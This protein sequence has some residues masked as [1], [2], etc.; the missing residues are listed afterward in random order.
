MNDRIV[1]GIDLGTQGL[2][3][4]AARA[5]DAAVLGEASA[6][7]QNLAPAPGWMEQ[8]PA[9]WWQSLCRLTRQLLHEMYFA[10]ERVAGIGLSGHMH[11]IAPLRADGSL[12]HN[13]IVWADTRTQAQAQFLAETMQA[14]LWNPAIAPYS[15][16][17]ILWL[18]ERRPAVYDETATVLFSKD[19]LRWRL[20]GELATDYSDASGSLMWDFQ[21]RTWDEALLADLDIPLSLLPQARDS[22]AQAGALTSEAASD[23]GLLPGT[24][25]AH[26]GGDAACAVVGAG[27]AGTDTLL[28]NAGTAV[29]VIELV[30]APTPF[31]PQH[32]VR[33]LFE[34]GVDGRR[35]VIGALNSAGHS[36]DWWRRTL[37]PA[38]SHADME[39]LAA[40]ETGGADGAIF[41]PWLQGTGTPY[42]LD[43]AHGVFAQLSATADQASLTRAVMDGVAMGMRLC[44]ESMLGADGLAGTRI[45]FTGGVPKGALMRRILAGVF[46]GEIRCRAFSDMSA[47][48][49]AAHGAVACGLADDAGAWLADFDYGEVAQTADESLVAEYDRMYARYKEWAGR[50]GAS[51]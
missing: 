38:R 1:L 37:D 28:I 34:L 33:Y 42:L 19:W 7:V 41:L 35:F 27:I 4:I 50:I 46:G 11:S 36:L 16:A 48:G 9:A 25:V 24:I 32:A 18:R 43:G 14:R 31:H 29:Q 44:A 13:C 40:A 23:L 26:G 6:P 47:L 3:V 2:K 22:S 10:P 45:L 5:D 15:L 21:A 12:A 17:K 39:A 30:D 49:A 20:T 51:F 8:E